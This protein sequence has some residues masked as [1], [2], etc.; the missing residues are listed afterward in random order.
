MSGI[1]CLLFWQYS[2]LWTTLKQSFTVCLSKINQNYTDSRDRWNVVV[3]ETLNLQTRNFS[4][5]SAILTIA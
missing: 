2:W 4:D 3:F 1:R 5:K